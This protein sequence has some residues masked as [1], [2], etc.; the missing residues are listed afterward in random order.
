MHK[1]IKRFIIFLDIE[2]YKN[3]NQRAVII[4]AKNLEKAGIDGTV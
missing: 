4:L 2:D 3:N 1:K